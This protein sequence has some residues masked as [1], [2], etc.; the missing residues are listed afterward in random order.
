MSD[1]H[2]TIMMMMVMKMNDT[3]Q[4]RSRSCGRVQQSPIEKVAVMSATSRA[5][6]RRNYRTSN[7]IGRSSLFYFD[8]VMSLL[9]I[10]FAITT[11]A[12]GVLSLPDGFI[13]ELVSHA[14]A[15]TGIFAP[16]PRNDNK[17]MLLLVAKEGQVKVIEDPDTHDPSGQNEDAMQILTIKDYICR[18]TERGLQSIVISPNFE[19]NRYVYLFYT[20]FKQGCYVYED[21]DETNL[22]L[23][24]NGNNPWN[25]IER[26][27]MNKT[28]LMLDYDSRVQIWRYDKMTR[29]SCV[30]FCGRDAFDS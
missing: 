18:N 27:T 7:S 23:D 10:L 8:V 19:T 11:T 1:N 17:P 5:S 25:V 4:Y 29:R 26:F 22:N 24:P 3:S 15:V 28:T 13:A 30:I 12:V 6:K 20:K 16:N 14:N 9:S 21:E 2:R